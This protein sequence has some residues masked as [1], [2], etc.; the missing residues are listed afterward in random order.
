MPADVHA[1]AHAQP[2]HH[3]V[4]VQRA[5]KA[6][7]HAPKPVKKAV[8]RPARTSVVVTVRPGQTLYSIARAHH[9]T[10]AAIV[11]ANSKVSIWRLMPGTKLT[12]PMPS[13]AV[14]AAKATESHHAK[15]RAS[16]ASQRTSAP[17]KA[18]PRSTT[19]RTPQSAKPTAHAPKPTHVK[20]YAGTPS[21][22]GYA[23]NLVTDG[24]RHREQL[25]KADL[26]SRAEVRSMIETTAKRYGVDPKLALAIGWQESTW[27]QN[28]VSVCD[29]VGVMQVMPSTAT[30]AA[31]IAGSQLDRLQAQDNITAGVV[32]LRYLTEHA[33]NR[34]EVIGSYY[35]GLGAMR[36]H[37]PYADTKRYI[38]SVNHHMANLPK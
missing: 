35:Q 17:K 26:P 18:T 24:D 1:S 3:H 4:H 19:K 5:A 33:R 30:W 25:A 10:V 11:K 23:K 2:Q 28:A 13:H 29:A 32:T 31:N 16:R 14:K 22:R 27:L 36:K 37:G 8:K 21:A 9:S 7:G 15:Q 20:K 38:K 6:P 34:D 12:V